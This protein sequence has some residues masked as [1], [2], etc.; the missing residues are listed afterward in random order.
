MIAVDTNV[1]TLR[2][3]IGLDN[4]TAENPEQFGAAV[5]WC[6]QGM[7]FADAL[8]LTGS[9]RAEQFATVDR[10]I[11]KPAGKCQAMEVVAI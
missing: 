8:H 2:E 1:L 7:D 6:E 5:D 4:V 10:K 11:A 3:V 9:G